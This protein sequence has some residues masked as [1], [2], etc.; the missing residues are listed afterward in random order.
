MSTKWGIASSGKISHDFVNALST[1]G[2]DS[3]HQV[4]MS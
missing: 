3:G 4:P 1:Y 2:D